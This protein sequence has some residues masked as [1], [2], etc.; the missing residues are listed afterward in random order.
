MASISWQKGHL[1]F[2]DEGRGTAI[3]LLHGFCESSALWDDWKEELL[4]DGF[5]IVCIDLPGFGD[6]TARAQ[7]IEEHAKAVS[8]VTTAIKIKQGVIIGHSMGG[9]VC[10]AVGAQSPQWLIGL[11]L[12]HSHP[13]ADTVSQREARH[14]SIDFI[15][16]NGH[17]HYV[18]QLIP[19]LFARNA[20]TSASFRRD[21]LI[22]R[23]SRS[24]PEH[25]TDAITAMASRQDR[26]EWLRTFP[27][28]VLFINGEKDPIYT[29]EQRQGQLALPAVS[30]VC[31]LNRSGHMG[32]IEEARV[33]QRAVRQ[34]VRFC[35]A[36]QPGIRT[37]RV[38]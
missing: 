23:A 8:A 33:T 10:L 37:H 1:H 11:G 27:R 22:L 36:W 13:F 15:R 12:F 31:L 6:S 26:S 17:L 28:P 9:Y 2:T 16:R 30:Q 5:R 3:I 4:E 14:K 18:K 34:F 7:T 35:V 24:A 20:G 29:D 19:R 32:M 38:G 25:I 21:L